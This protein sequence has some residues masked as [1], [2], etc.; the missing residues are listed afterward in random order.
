MRDVI[1]TIIIIWLLFRVADL[2][3]SWSKKSAKDPGLKTHG[4]ENPPR[5]DLKEALRRHLNKEGEYVD[6]EDL[7]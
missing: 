2:L 6:Y 7:R 4:P 3:K 5:K 1:W